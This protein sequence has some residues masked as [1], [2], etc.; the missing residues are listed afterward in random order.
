MQTGIS[1][2]MIVMALAN[3]S[4]LIFDKDSIRR[5]HALTR[6]TTFTAGVLIIS[7]LG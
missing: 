3:L 2:F 4:V 6:A 5:E 7:A 1:I